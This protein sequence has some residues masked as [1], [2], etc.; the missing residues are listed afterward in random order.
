[1]KH[2]FSFLFFPY[3][4]I[5]ILSRIAIAEAAA[6]GFVDTAIVGAIVAAIQA[7][8]AES[9]LM[10]AASSTIFAPCRLACHHLA[11]SAT[12]SQQRS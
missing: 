7:A 4:L 6:V 5:I 1:M 11:C 9:T 3:L 8:A 10:A 12:A 2:T